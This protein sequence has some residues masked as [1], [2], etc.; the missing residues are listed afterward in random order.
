MAA[1]I[2]IND[3]NP[4]W[5][6]PDILVVPGNDPNGSFGSPIAGQPNYLWAKVHNTGN[7]IIEGAIVNF[8]WSNPTMGVLR[9]NSTLVGFSFV[10]LEIGESKDVL[11]LT[12]WIPVVVNDGH[13]C[14]VVEIIT[15]LDPLPTPLQDA[16]DPPSFDQI[17]QRNL[18]VVVM[19]SKMQFMI[20]PIQISASPRRAKLSKISIEIGKL[21]KEHEYKILNQLGHEKLTKLKEDAVK[22]GISRQGGCHASKETIGKNSLDFKLEEQTSTKVYV[23]FEQSSK[24]KETG[25]QIFNLIERVNG[26]I[27]GGN[28]ILIIKK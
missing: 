6:S 8:Y 1:K 7:L 19:T 14:V 5:V 15:P 23:H 25:Y 17:A 26:K 10:D 22:F 9:S 13:E 20:L 16:F 12:P 4:W 2:Q 21:D 27:V 24:S 28:S 3:G 11:C 18:Q